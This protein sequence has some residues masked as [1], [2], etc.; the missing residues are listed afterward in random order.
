MRF[1]IIQPSWDHSEI[2]SSL[3]YFIKKSGNQVKIIYDWSHP[4]GNYLDYFCDLI[5]FD[6]SVK[7]NYKSPKHHIRDFIKAHKIIFV[8]EIHLKKFLN[9]QVFRNMLPKMYTFNHLTK[10]IEYDIKV[11][12]LGKIPFNR[13]LNSN[14]YLVNNLYNPNIENNYKIENRNKKYLIVGNPKYREL[15]YL[16]R[17][18]DN[19]DI[20]INFVVRRPLEINKPF[21]KIHQDLST[22]KLI[23]LIE[24]TDFIIT[25]FKNDSVYHKD[26]IS[27]IV[28]FAISFGKPLIMDNEYQQLTGCLGDNNLVYKNSF[29]D[30]RRKL[31]Y[32]MEMK[33][34]EYSKMVKNMIDNRNIKIVEQY[35]N[36][37][38]IFN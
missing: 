36:F 26:R 37:N 6:D 18:D 38:L 25:L 29:T 4:E 14:K 22:E 28:P 2:L 10:K 8:D 24:E 21:L 19:L 34:N 16:E 7:I 1:V 3:L 30:F 32:S 23:E 11:L 9:K 15:S 12:S 31:K 13:C 33:N 35:L 27:G 20:E 17:L 5:G